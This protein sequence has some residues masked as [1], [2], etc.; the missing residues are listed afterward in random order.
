MSATDIGLW[1]QPNYEL[2]TAEKPDL[3]LADALQPDLKQDLE[4]LGVPVAFVS[5]QKF[6]DVGIALRLVGQVLDHMTDADLAATRLEQ[7]LANLKKSLPVARP[8]VL[9]LSGLLPVLINAA[10]PE[11]Y[12]GDLVQ[13]LGGDNVVKEGAQAA[14][15]Y[16]GFTELSLEPILA[17]QPDVVLAISAGPPG[18]PTITESLASNAAWRDVPTVKN[19]RVA[20]IG[21]AE[22]FLWA[23]GPRA[24]D[25]LTILANRLFP[26]TASQ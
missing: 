16:P 25:A 22:L 14:H 5:V 18:A 24:V 23:P 13:L 21:P 9:V 8:R 19:G 4:K 11:S 26:G 12:V 1:N 7:E 2:I 15:G 6:A 3:I 17:P 20:E 10:K